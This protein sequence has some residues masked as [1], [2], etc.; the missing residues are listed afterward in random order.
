MTERHIFKSTSATLNMHANNI[1]NA[2][3]GAPYLHFT[4]FTVPWQQPGCLGHR[5]PVKGGEKMLAAKEELMKSEIIGP[6]EVGP[7]RCIRCI[8]SAFINHLQGQIY[9]I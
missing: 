8:L 7:L 6:A 4:L 9:F 1:I 2:L 5:V 3:S